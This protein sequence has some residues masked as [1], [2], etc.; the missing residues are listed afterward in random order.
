MTDY[1]TDQGQNSS[2]PV[3]VERRHGRG[4]SFVLFVLGAVVALLAVMWFASSGPVGDPATSG[5]TNVTIE[6]PTEV[7]PTEVPA[8]P[9]AV[10]PMTPETV[11][12]E[13][14]TPETVTP[15]T[16]TTTDQAPATTPPANP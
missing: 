12:P 15:E 4:T 9:E 5:D 1:R 13:T 16:G 6:T 8:A 14:V 3:Y 2:R 11:T 10:V 7:P